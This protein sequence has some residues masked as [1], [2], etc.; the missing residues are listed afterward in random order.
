MTAGASVIAV[1]IALLLCPFPA[2]GQ[3]EDSSS[4]PAS[5]PALKHTWGEIYFQSVYSHRDRDNIIP[6]LTVRQGIRSLNINGKPLEFYVKA[7][8]LYDLNGDFWNNLGEAGVGAR[9]RPSNQYGLVLFSELLEGFYTGRHGE[10]EAPENNYTYLFTGAAFGQWWGVQPEQ[11]Q[12]TRW[13]VPFTGWREVYADAIYNGHDHSNIISTSYYREGVLL[14]RYGAF[15]YNAYIGVGAATD[16]HGDSWN[17]Y[18]RIGPGFGI[19]PFENIDM[20]LNCDFFEGIHYRGI[21]EE[22]GNYDDVNI[23]LSYSNSW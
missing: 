17:N 2:H 21:E 9:Y 10:D 1:F 12:G 19:R 22:R 8:M 18:L 5:V 7:R 13:Y 14:G 16:L 6:D 11:V 23:T 20:Q 3:E 15:N 4:E